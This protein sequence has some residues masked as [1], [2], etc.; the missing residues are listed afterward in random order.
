MGSFRGLI[1]GGLLLGA[2]CALSTQSACEAPDKPQQKRQL[3][4]PP[5]QVAIKKVKQ[6]KAKLVDDEGELLP[7]DLVLGGFPVPRGFEMKR[8]R[9]H[10]WFLRSLEVSAERAASY[11]QKR[12]FTSS[13][14]RSSVGGV[15][16]DGAQLREA[17]QL[18]KVSI[19]ISP[20]KGRKNACE[21]YIKRH[22]GPPPQK[23][24][25]EQTEAMHREEA[26]Y[27]D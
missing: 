19:H 9:E 20:T 12:L 11:A 17:P 7:S 18:P 22:A 1:Q 8:S 3:L 14:V 24:T 5:D 27:A 15:R 16:F 21:L 25:R 6:E 26:R 10:E 13:L 23:L 2:L 4:T